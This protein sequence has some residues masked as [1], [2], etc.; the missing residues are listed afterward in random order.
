MKPNDFD[1]QHIM[2]REPE[3]HY[4][5]GSPRGGRF[6]KG[7]NSR[8]RVEPRVKAENAWVRH[9]ADRKENEMQIMRLLNKISPENFEKYKDKIF[10]SFFNDEEDMQLFIKCLFLKVITE[11]NFIKIY[12]NLCEE[13]I[14]KTGK[15][16]NSVFRRLIIQ[17][18]QNTFEDPIKVSDDIP[19]ESMDYLEKL[20]KV[21]TQNILAVV[22]IGELF[23]RK[24]LPDKVIFFCI[25]FLM[26]REESV[27]INFELFIKLMT[28]VGKTLDQDKNKEKVDQIFNQATEY[29][30]KHKLPSKIKFLFMNLKDLKKSEWLA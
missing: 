1:I 28:T 15:L 11:P 19:K 25:D 9:K 7:R 20:G 18:C 6:F 3:A 10:D 14:K 27:D 17:K 23:V 21:K 26:E 16:K 2:M 13:L 4:W 8:G 29:S 5:G 22:F 12:A 30:T 24:I